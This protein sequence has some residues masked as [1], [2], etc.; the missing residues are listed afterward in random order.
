MAAMTALVVLGAPRCTAALLLASGPR[1]A[2]QELLRTY[3]FLQFL[4][5][6]VSYSLAPGPS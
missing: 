6:L 2:V 3:V 4:W 1:G 5:A